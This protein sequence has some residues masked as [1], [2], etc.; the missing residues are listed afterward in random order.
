MTRF[1]LIALLFC[2]AI[3]RVSAQVDPA[4]IE[5]LKKKAEA[6]QKM[7][8]DMIRSNPDSA[9]QAINQYLKSTDSTTSKIKEQALK[10]APQGAMV[11]RYLNTK[12]VTDTLYTTVQFSGSLDVSTQT[13]NQSE[14]SHSSVHLTAVQAPLVQKGSVW[15]LQLISTP[16]FDNE[17][18]QLKKNKVQGTLATYIK[19]R[20][21]VSGTASFS[22]NNH[23]TQQVAGT[24]LH[25]STVESSTLPSGTMEQF[26]FSFD[27]LTRFGQVSYTKAMRVH[28]A[29][30][31]DSLSANGNAISVSNSMDYVVPVG[32]AAN[33]D[34]SQYN[35]NAMKQDK[36]GNILD[37]LTNNRL[38]TTTIH[39][40]GAD[41]PIL[42]I[43]KTPY[44]FKLTCN[45]FHTD[46][47]GRQEQIH[48]TAFIGKPILQYEAVIY[49]KVPLQDKKMY[50]YEHWLPKGPKVDGSDDTKG[51][52][53]LSFYVVVRDK[54]DTTK[55]YSG[56]YTANWN[57][58]EVSRYPGFCNNY[59]AYTPSPNTDPDLTFQKGMKQDPLFNADSVTDNI[60]QT[61]EG[62]GKDGLVKIHCMDYAA[63]GKLQATVILDDGT[64][65]HA[66]PYY[67]AQKEYITIPCDKEDNKLADYWEEQN[68]ILHK[69]YYPEWDEDDKPANQRDNGDGYTMFEE[70]RGFAV[71]KP[72]ETTPDKQDVH[73]RTDPF[74]KDVFVYDRDN[75]FQQ[76]YEADNPADL[77]WHYVVPN[78]KQFIYLP[79]DIKNIN[80]RWVNFNRA[81][82]YYYY[83]QYCIVLQQ[84]EGTSYDN[85]AAG[86]SWTRSEF[87]YSGDKDKFKFQHEGAMEQNTNSPLKKYIKCSIYPA[88]MEAAY[89]VIKT[90]YSEAAY[91]KV[92]QAQM[93]TTVIH[94]VGHCIGIKHHMAPEGAINVDSLSQTIP[95]NTDGVLDCAIRY[96]MDKEAHD[97]TAVST[98]Y[99]R[100]CRKG[101]KAVYWSY[102]YKVNFIG[103]RVVDDKNNYILLTV[104]NAG[105]KASDDCYGQI[106]VKSKPGD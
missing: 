46:G 77:H 10:S 13:P 31:H 60:A 22:S 53:S 56:T 89:G 38:T 40:D 3:S 12:T 92:M 27:T 93:K 83:S 51:D 32:V 5:A 52:D 54:K 21:Q 7:N 30:T 35:L 39:N 99:N 91:N 57:L 61:K 73:E 96:P 87:D 18:A 33:T 64:Q 19:N 20:N 104:R 34:P 106:S 63:W 62:K 68:N 65:I 47:L 101:E 37:S 42:M 81:N 2:I 45:Y 55:M 72:K 1:T 24:T 16:E 43:E 102:I 86:L 9:L 76:Y 17:A 85:T 105:T 14:A 88:V 75:L 25:A 79:L 97:L 82:P 6:L 26:V 74:T 29:S 80:H 67:D 69:G 90:K 98:T 23:T 71:H 36:A 41:R 103:N 58:A 95:A 44:G 8:K 15:S 4:T 50:A 28:Q 66:R 48:I 59:P 84:E 100:Y 94:E 11:Q 70:Y 49:P 78:K